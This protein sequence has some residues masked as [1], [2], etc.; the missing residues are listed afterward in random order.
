MKTFLILLSLS[1][2]SLHAENLVL[3]I[4]QNGNLGGRIQYRANPGKSDK[5]IAHINPLPMKEIAVGPTQN[6]GVGLAFLMAFQ[7]TP[8]FR[9]HIAADGKVRLALEIVKTIEGGATDDLNLALLDMGTVTN[10]DFYPQF[11]AFNKAPDFKVIDTIDAD[12]KIG[13]KEIDITE[14][15]KASANQPSGDKPLIWFAIYLPIEKL[16]GTTPRHVVFAG[17]PKLIG[18]K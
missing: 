16:E 2:F 1:A 14:V 10:R 18:I 12:P 4:Y 6:E 8:E 5:A 9:Q 17:T 7:T 13:L 3:D 15:L 11:G